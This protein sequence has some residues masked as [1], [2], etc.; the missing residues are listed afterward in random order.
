MKIRV[1]VPSKG[2]KKAD[3][4][5]KITLM[6]PSFLVFNGLTAR[7]VSSLLKK[8]KKKGSDLP[9]LIPASV[10]RRLFRAI[11]RAK[12]RHPDWALVDLKTQDGTKV[13]L[14]L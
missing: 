3:K 9:V 6:L 4:D 5:T 14:K 1:Y 2:G 7:I 10:F 12:R 13:F 11:R 8:A